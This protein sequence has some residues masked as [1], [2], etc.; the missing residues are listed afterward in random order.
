M[1]QMDRCVCVCVCL[2][3]CVCVWGVAWRKGGIW[4]KILLRDG[5]VVRGEEE[6]AAAGED[7]NRMTNTLSGKT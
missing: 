3:V 4:L 6:E 5:W 7:F 1:S 2:C